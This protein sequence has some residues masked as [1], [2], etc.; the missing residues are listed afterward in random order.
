[1]SFQ[2][3]DYLSIYAAVLSTVVFIWNIVRTIPRFKV[4]LG[5]GVSDEN[6]EV[7]SGIFI[8]VRNPSPH[9]VHI[10]SLSLLTRLW[11]KAMG[12]GLLFCIILFFTRS[13]NTTY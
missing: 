7:Q 11:H 1:M 10:G 4:D 13:Y 5:V 6:G 12:S 9:A 8:N 2:P 3:K